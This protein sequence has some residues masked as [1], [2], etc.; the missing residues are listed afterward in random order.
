MRIR[1]SCLVLVVLLIPAWGRASGHNFDL[2]AG[3]S[4]VGAK[5]NPS[6]ASAGSKNFAAK[7]TSEPSKDEPTLY[8]WHFAVA[9]TFHTR[10]VYAVVAD[11]SGHFYEHGYTNILKRRS[12]QQITFMLGPRWES[13][14]LWG[15]GR[16]MLH[17]LPFGFRFDNQD[18][19]RTAVLAA[20]GASCEW[21]LHTGH[22][23]MGFRAIYDRLLVKD[24]G[25]QNRFSLV[26]TRRFAD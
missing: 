20:V 19:S 16:V 22:S 5:A 23:G 25:P 12:L 2:A 15:K 21:K 4:R 9:R 26:V 14:S 1:A 6:P 17:A 11:V 8:G 18:N 13:P 7:S 10:K 24:S 3:G